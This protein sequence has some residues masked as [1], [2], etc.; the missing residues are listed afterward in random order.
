E[1][2]LPVE[3]VAQNQMTWKDG[4]GD[5]VGADPYLVFK[6]DRP[7][8]VQGI[9]LRFVLTAPRNEASVLQVFWS[10]RGEEFAE[11]NRSAVRYLSPAP[12][13]RVLTVWVNRRIEHIRI[14][15]DVKP[16]HFELREITLLEQRDPGAAP[17]G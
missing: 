9:R 5:G 1:V 8:Y 13:E 14:D 3:P 11:V 16:C 4:T 12:K 10:D 7:T 6:L 15:P 17:R 2:K